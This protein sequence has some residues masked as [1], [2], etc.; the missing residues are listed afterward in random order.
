MNPIR[1]ATITNTINNND[2]V[3]NPESAQPKFL[4]PNFE[5]MPDELK[6]LKNWLLWVPIWNGS[7]WTKRPIQPSGYGA[8]STNPKHW[9]SFEEVK[10]AYERAVQRGHIEFRERAKPVQRVSVGG[11]GFVFD[12]QPDPNGLVYAGVD[13]DS[14]AF[15]D[16]IASISAERVKRLGSY[17][18]G[19]GA[20]RGGHVIVNARPL[21]SGIA[22]NGIEMYTGG[23]FFT[24][25]G[26]SQEGSQ[27]VAAPDE[28]AALA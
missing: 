18:E 25:T 26:R 9:S 13:F 5:A 2:M 20:G 3:P 24:M 8:R 28:F 12:G 22:H 6:Q 21:A 27:I 10:Q 7:K 11:V 23:R 19:S 17:V 15:K 4:R 1:E 16:E 14:G